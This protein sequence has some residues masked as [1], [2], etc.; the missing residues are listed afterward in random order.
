MKKRKGPG[1]KAGPEML[2]Y[3]GQRLWVTMRVA[4]LMEK[5]PTLV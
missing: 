5:Q 3:E 2:T 4:R 1:Q